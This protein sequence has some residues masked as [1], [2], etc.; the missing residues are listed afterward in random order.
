[1]LPLGT[2]I[3]MAPRCP[4]PAA[5]QK[6]WRFEEGWGELWAAPTPQE[7]NCCFSEVQK[8]V[9]PSDWAAPGV[10]RELGQVGETRGS[11]SSWCHSTCKGCMDALTPWLY[12]E[13]MRPQL[14]VS[15]GW[16]TSVPKS[17]REGKGPVW[18]F[19]TDLEQE[20]S[21]RLCLSRSR[22]SPLWSRPPIMAQAQSS[23]A[24]PCPAL[25]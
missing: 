1:M 22:P 14:S 10:C 16:Y 21:S 15:H 8:P 24:Q 5:P 4:H 7:A 3:C 13:F 18:C 6:G 2:A 17:L 23:I 20:L 9:H 11:L 19:Q 12:L 25:A